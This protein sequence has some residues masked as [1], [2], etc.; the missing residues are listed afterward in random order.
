MTDWVVAVH[1]F[2]FDAE[3]G[4]DS[5]SRVWGNCC[6]R[7]IRSPSGICAGSDIV[8]PMVECQYSKGRLDGGGDSLP[9]FPQLRLFSHPDEGK[10]KV[11]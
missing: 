7:M 4:R 3:C 2:T 10:V 1:I 8:L 6:Q 9:I 11:L 5:P